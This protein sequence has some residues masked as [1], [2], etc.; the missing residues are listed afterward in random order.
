MWVT[1]VKNNRFGERVV[2]LD[3]LRPVKKKVEISVRDGRMH[4]QRYKFIK[5][6]HRNY[7]VKGLAKI[8][9]RS[10]RISTRFFQVLH[11][12]M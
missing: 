9:E 6:L 4:I 12:I 5:Q 2:D 7:G 8:H 11:N 10:P 1:G 3:I